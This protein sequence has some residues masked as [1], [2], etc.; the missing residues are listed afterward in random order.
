MVTDQYREPD[1]WLARARV[2]TDRS[3]PLLLLMRAARVTDRGSRG[4]EI[5]GYV[6]GARWPTRRM[7]PR[8]AAMAYYWAAFAKAAIPDD[9]SAWPNATSRKRCFQFGIGSVHTQMKF[10]N[11]R[12]DWMEKYRT[13]VIASGAAGGA[14]PLASAFLSKRR[15][16]APEQGRA[17]AGQ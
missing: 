17:P 7:P 8:N 15:A 11:D 2:R 9:R 6:F 16:L 3:P 10:H 13:Q 4:G 1:R 14:R 12:L 5:G